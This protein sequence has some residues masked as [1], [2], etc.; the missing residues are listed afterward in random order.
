MN[1]VV[2]SD[3]PDSYK[4][5]ETIMQNLFLSYYYRAYLTES[6]CNALNCGSCKYILNRLTLH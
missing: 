1:V 4:I 5:T 3:T 2:Y 6:H